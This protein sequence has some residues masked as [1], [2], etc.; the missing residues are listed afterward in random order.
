MQVTPADFVQWIS[1]GVAQ[2]PI[3]TGLDWLV[4]D[5][6]FISEV[7]QMLG[8]KIEARL[9][10]SKEFALLSEPNQYRVQ[11]AFERGRLDPARTEG[12]AWILPGDDDFSND[13]VSTAEDF[14]TIEFEDIFDAWD[15]EAAVREFTVAG[16]L[17]ELILPDCGGDAAIAALLKEPGT[18]EGKAAWYRLLCLGCSFSTLL[19]TSPRER[20]IDLWENRLTDDFWKKT[21]PD[22][23]DAGAKVDFNRNLDAFF[24]EAIHNLFSN[25]NASGEDAEFWRRV[26]YDFRKMHYFV[27]QNHLPETILEYTS[28]PKADGPGLSK[29]LKTGEIQDDFRDPNETRFTGVIG[30]SMSS[31]L[32][33]I[34]RELARLE[35][36]DERFSSACYYVNR[37][38]RRVARWLG[39]IDDDGFSVPTFSDLLK[40][41]QAINGKW[42]NPIHAMLGQYDLPL[43]WYAL[44]K[45]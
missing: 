39:W 2:G 14:E 16:P 18:I 9:L 3:Q 19:G 44:N 22:S 15:E 6:P 8:E 28:F 13:D 41:S 5:D 10:A 29:F 26:F 25:G 43:Q 30:Q 34:M 36:I 27:F 33:F 37:P 12:R 17:G 31:P 21:I 42:K 38:A 35:V 45:H 11:L 32:L 23:L 7:A 4:S 1:E 40:Y 20:V 24:E